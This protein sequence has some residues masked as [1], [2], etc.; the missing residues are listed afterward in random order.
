MDEFLIYGRAALA[1][2]LTQQPRTPLAR[3]FVNQYLSKT[4]APADDALT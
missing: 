1:M 2:G 3:R 4:F